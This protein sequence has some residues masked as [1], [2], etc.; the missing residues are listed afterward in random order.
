MERSVAVVPWLSAIV[1]ISEYGLNDVWDLDCIG[2]LS[3]L[4]WLQKADWRD[5]VWYGALHYIVRLLRVKLFY[6][7]CRR[8]HLF[9]F[10]CVH[11]KRQIYK[12]EWPRF[13]NMPAVSWL[14]RV[15]AVPFFVT[16]MSRWSW[17]YLGKIK[18]VYMT[19][20]PLVVNMCTKYQKD[21]CSVRRIT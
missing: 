11:N 12:R 13:E 20:I 3:V 8:P 4:S 19:D 21:P 16:A 5:S 2:A 14:P 6:F 1:V 18:V 9:I 17:R 7:S 15:A 10:Y